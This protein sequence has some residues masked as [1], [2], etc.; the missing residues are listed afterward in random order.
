MSY[1][2]FILSYLYIFSNEGVGYNSM[3]LSEFIGM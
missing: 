3:C 2:I 1:Q